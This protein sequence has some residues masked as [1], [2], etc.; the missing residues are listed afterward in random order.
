[1]YSMLYRFVGHCALCARTKAYMSMTHCTKW[2][3][4][5][6]GEVGVVV[7]SGRKYQ[8]MIFYFYPIPLIFCHKNHSQ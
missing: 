2:G 5:L 7:T 4:R 3:W 8:N 6:E 1:M